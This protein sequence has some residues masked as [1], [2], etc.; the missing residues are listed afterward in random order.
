LVVVGVGVVD[1]DVV[2]GVWVV[3]V[4][5]GGVVATFFSAVVILLQ[6]AEDGFQCHPKGPGMKLALRGEM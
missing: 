4:V 6:K 1:A 3:S 5:A 2:G